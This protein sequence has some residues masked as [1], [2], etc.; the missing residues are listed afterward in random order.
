MLFGL[1]ADDPLTYGAAGLLLIAVALLASFVPA[2]AAARVNPIEA[3]R[4]E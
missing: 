3:L 1:K 2:R 4:H